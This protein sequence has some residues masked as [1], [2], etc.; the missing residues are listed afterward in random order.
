[1]KI[2]IDLRSLS[3]TYLF[4]VTKCPINDYKTNQINQ[5]T[6]NDKHTKHPPKF[7]TISKPSTLLTKFIKNN[8]YFIFHPNQWW[9]FL[10]QLKQIHCQKIITRTLKSSNS[11]F[12]YNIMFCISFRTAIHREIFLTATSVQLIMACQEIQQSRIIIDGIIKSK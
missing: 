2:N 12:N 9:H 6:V 1:M 11:C 8:F 7:S 4:L 3:G 5:P 10:R